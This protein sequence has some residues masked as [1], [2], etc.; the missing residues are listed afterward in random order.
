MKFQHIF[1][2]TLKGRNITKYGKFISAKIPIS[3]ENLCFQ[4][5]LFI[6]LFA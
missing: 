1:A 5:L 6:V 2:N 4:I 3:C